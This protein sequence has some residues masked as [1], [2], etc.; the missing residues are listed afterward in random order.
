MQLELY[1][2][3]EYVCKIP[4]ERL[5]HFR[6]ILRKDNEFAHLLC[7]VTYVKALVYKKFC[8]KIADLCLFIS[9]IKSLTM[10][11]INQLQIFFNYFYLSFNTKL[12]P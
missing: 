8:N 4:L 1:I 11:D 3:K 6:H 10:K 2:K 12:T 9:A 5:K 7:Q